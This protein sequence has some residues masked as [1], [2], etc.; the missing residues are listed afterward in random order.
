MC[1]GR[2]DE[3][4]EEE[5][6]M[7]QMETVWGMVGGR[8][9]L[10]DASNCSEGTAGQGKREDTSDLGG[11]CCVGQV[12]L[13]PWTFVARYLQHCESQPLLTQNLAEPA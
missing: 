9:V 6:A 4:E 3:K 1:V 10:G 5:G 2:N 11:N 7:G 8:R 13:R 12:T